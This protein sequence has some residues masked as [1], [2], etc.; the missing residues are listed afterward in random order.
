MCYEMTTATMIHL[1]GYICL[2]K[3]IG[4]PAFEFTTTQPILFRGQPL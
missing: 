3:C 2:S 1:T 4:Q